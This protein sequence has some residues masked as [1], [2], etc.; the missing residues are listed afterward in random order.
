MIIRYAKED[1]LEFLEKGLLDVRNIEKRPMNDL[2]VTKEDSESFMKGI[3]NREVRIIDDENGRPAAF[4]YHRTDHPIPYVSGKF[5]WIDL[6]YV[7]K[8]L[9]GKGMGSALYNDALRIANEK[10]V[11]RIVID[12]FDPNDRSKI[13]HSKLD[14]KPFYTIYIKEI[15]M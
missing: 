14:F 8:D 7:R 4:M 13:F 6:L 12:I 1:D 3:R 10:G 15:Q 5:L 11:D 2:P 9:R